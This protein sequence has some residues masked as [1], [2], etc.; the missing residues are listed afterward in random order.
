M[1]WRFIASVSPLWT[2]G[3]EWVSCGCGPVLAFSPAGALGAGGFRSGCGLGSSGL[4]R[5]TSGWSLAAFRAARGCGENEPGG[6]FGRFVVLVGED[7]G[8]GVG[9][10]HDAGVPEL[11][12]NRLE[13][14]AGGMGET[15]RPVAQVVQPHRRQP[16]PLDEGPETSGQKIRMQRLTTSHGEHV[17]GVVPDQVVRT[18]PNA[19]MS[20]WLRASV[21]SR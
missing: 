11:L 2:V 21:A 7:A 17:P 15:G 8:V 14:R 19:S 6:G 18:S 13:V 10:Q 5:R 1:T 3:V 12:L 16:G 20:C 9:R 4:R